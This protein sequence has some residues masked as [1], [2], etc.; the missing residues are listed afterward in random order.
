MLGN[1]LKNLP[2]VKKPERRLSFDE[3]LKWTLIILLLYFTLAQIPLW[4]LDPSWTTDYF[5]AVRAIIAGKFGS[6]ITLGIGPIV[7]AGI[8]LQLLVGVQLLPIDL[9]TPDGRQTFQA[10]EQILTIFVALFEGIVYV[11]MGGLPAVNNDFMIKLLLVG[12]LFLGTMLIVLLDELSQKWGFISGISLFI[13][14]GV[15]A[16]I[17]VAAFNPL[18]NPRNPKMAAGRIPSALQ[19]FMGGDPRSGLVVLVPIIFTVVV[20]LITVYV[21]AINVEIPLSFGRIG[22]LATKWP[23]NLFYTGNIPVILAAALLAN[24]QLWARLLQ[25]SGMPILGTVDTSNSPA[26]GL[27]F[28]INPPR[29]LIYSLLNPV[30]FFS[31]LFKDIS[32]V[33]HGSPLGL[34]I[35]NLIYITMILRAIFY[36]VFMVA[37]SVLFSIFWVKTANQDPKSVAEQISKAGM[38]R[39]GFRSDPRVMETILNLYIPQLTVIGGAAVGLLAAFADFTN[40]IGGGTGILLTVMIIYRMYQ[41]IVQEHFMDMTPVLKKFVA[42]S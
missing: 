35:Y 25:R 33:I 41:T 40:A 13:A 30:A 21:Q 9:N 14:A 24:L 27:I 26:T 42:T 8:I 20:F 31:G 6:I 22:G 28:F 19:Y 2:E 29:D 32:Q 10:L 23:L 12:Q 11:F 37:G 5:E 16:E 1:I 15:A 3:K 4:G 18:P 34:N 7:T 17:M 39:K 38:F 36:L